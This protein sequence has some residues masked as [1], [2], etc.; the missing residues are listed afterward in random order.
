MDPL[1]TFLAD[2]HPDDRR[3]LGDLVAEEAEARGVTDPAAPEAA[4][5]VARVLRELA[6]R[7]AVELDAERDPPPDDGWDDDPD[8]DAPAIPYEEAELGRVATASIDPTPA[9]DLALGRFLESLPGR[10]RKGVLKR[11][12]RQWEAAGVRDPDDPRAATPSARALVAEA[13]QE[14]FE[15]PARTVDVPAM[16]DAGAARRRG[17]PHRPPAAGRRR[18]RGGDPRRP[19]PPRRGRG[20]RDARPV[21]LPG[22]ARRAERGRPGPLGG[23]GAAGRRDRRGRFPGLAAGSRA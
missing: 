4:P 16:T 18:G 9:F 1:D 3:L 5:V 2:L 11:A 8:W 20:A 15:P 13:L 19:R 14:G 12:K 17:P 7:L 23:G 21:G 10:R 6:E 22:D